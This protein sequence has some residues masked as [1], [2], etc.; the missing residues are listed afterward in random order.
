MSVLLQRAR[1][2]GKCP[3]SLLSDDRVYTV[4]DFDVNAL[5]LL[6]PN[7]AFDCCW[8]NLLF[9]FSFVV[10]TNIFYRFLPFVCVIESSAFCLRS[11][12]SAANDFS[13]LLQVS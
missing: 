3:L 8:Y 2:S 9:F 5:R 11:D 6:S 12:D 7:G 1:G 4:D 13:I 10:L